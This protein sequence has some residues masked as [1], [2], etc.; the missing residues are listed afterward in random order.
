MSNLISKLHKS[1][2]LGRI[3]HT[4]DY[5]LQ[6]EL[7]NCKTVLDLGC[8]PSSPL[9]YCKNITYSVGVEA[10]VPYLKESE[11]KKIH[12]KYF[13]KKI[14]GIDFPENSFDAVILIEVLEHLSKKAGNEIIKKSYKWAKN[15]V[16]I[17]TPNGYFSMGNVDENNFQKHLSGWSIDELNNLGFKVYGMSGAKFL[18]TDK[19][20]VYDWINQEDN[21][22]FSNMR[23]R[24]KKLFYFINAFLQI[25]TYYKPRLAFGLFLI[26]QKNV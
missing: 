14:E 20:K 7:K 4:L 6:R 22:F 24:P 12:T 26:K 9:Q 23:F 13:N 18:Y 16:I 5:C 19:N 17:S 21:V 2:F 3:F 15:K 25:F 10:F 11:K 1:I 8:G